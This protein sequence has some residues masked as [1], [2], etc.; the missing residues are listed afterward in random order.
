MISSGKYKRIGIAGFGAVGQ[1]VAVALQQESCGLTLAAIT[2]GNL[3]KARQHA[4]ELLTD[5]PPVTTLAETAVLSDL[6]VEAAP[7]LCF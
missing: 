7:V 3:D 1:R 4:A 2:S 5:P 6:V